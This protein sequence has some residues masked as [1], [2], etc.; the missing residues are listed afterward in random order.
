M[1]RPEMPTDCYFHKVVTFRYGD[2]VLHFRVSQDLFSSYDVD[3]GTQRLLRTLLRGD[4]TFS[5]VLDLGCGYGPVGLALKKARPTCIVHMVD[6][7]ALAVSYARQ[8]AALNGMPDVEVYG[9]LGY[10]DVTAQDFDL[11]AGNIPAK[12]GRPVIA[13]FLQDAHRYLRPGGQVAVVVV[14]ALQ[15][16]VAEVL[17][18]PAIDVLH[19][20]RWPGHT[21]W[22]YRFHG[23]ALADMSS[24]GTALERGV[25]D[26][27]T[28]TFVCGGRV[29]TLQTAH[30]L[31]ETDA[32]DPPGELL[33]KGLLEIP[34]QA[35]RQALAFNP[36]QGYVPVALWA[37]FRPER[38]LLVDR[39]LLGL[40]WSRRN[41][42]QNGCPPEQVTLWHQVGLFVEDGAGVDL[43]VGVVR[44]EEGRPAL[45]VLLDQAVAQTRPGGW[46]ALAAGST[47][48]TRLV[49]LARADGRLRIR[50]RQRRKGVSLL[51]LERR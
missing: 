27:A 5:R 28:T 37:R 6:R 30:N 12:A 23:P 10:D 25:Y 43:V 46:I 11:I 41:L 9:S 47:A 29:L 26:R 13:H 4:D 40:R 24:G 3:I 33:L 1:D 51:I 17:D 42:L 18:N 48:V 7:D 34:V 45:T 35:V 38:L 31:S 32:P 36:G 50:E 20:E 49:N 15:P 2:Q 22:R 21:V 44:E 14:D 16:L 19:R 39:D 8:N